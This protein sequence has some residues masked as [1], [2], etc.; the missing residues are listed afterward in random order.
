MPNATTASPPMTETISSASAAASTLFLGHNGEWWDSSLI[1]AVIFAALAGAAVGITT[2]GSIVSHKRETSAAELA[3]EKYKLDTESKISDS[4]ARALEARLE[5]EKF[6]APRVLDGILK[7][8]LGELAKKHPGQ[9]YA[10]SV[11]VG[12]EASDL[13]C[14]FDSVLQ[15]VKWERV[16]PFGNITVDTACGIVGVNTVSSVNIRAAPTSSPEVEKLLHDLA[17]ILNANG[18]KAQP[19]F[20]P[21]NIPAANV[22]Y[23]MV[24]TK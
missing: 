8:Q 24:G 23:L 4:T 5:L 3:L 10:L 6:K 11:A 13:L 1:L 14:E 20:D 17:E 18:I 22:I 19:A 7:W 15:S 12:A 16:P 2:A 9:K 21:K